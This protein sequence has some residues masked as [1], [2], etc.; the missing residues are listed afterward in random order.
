MKAKRLLAVFVTMSLL[1]TTCLPSL[2]LGVQGEAGN[3]A[4]PSAPTQEEGL[5]AMLDAEGIATTWGENF[6]QTQDRLHHENLTPVDLSE[7]EY[8]ELDVYIEDVDAL[9]AAFSA[10]GIDQF[11]FTVSANTEGNPADAYPSRRWRSDANILDQIRKSG[12][13]HVKIR[14]DAFVPGGETAIHE[15]VN[16]ANCLHWGVFIQGSNAG[17]PISVSDDTVKI[18]N[19][20]G[21]RIVNPAAPTEAEGLVGMLDAE[22]VKTTWGENFG[23]TQ[24]RLHHE[25][26][27]PVD[28]SEAEYIELD[29]YIEDVDAL[30]A[31]F[32]ASGIDQFTF[33]VSAN[34]E[35]NPAD[36]YPSRRWRSDANILD[37]I[38]KS[39]WNHVKIR[40][41]A[42]VPGGE[43][44][45]HEGVN[46]ANCL[47]W[48]VFI[49]GSNAG[50]PISVSE[51]AVKIANIC[52]TRI[53][54]PAAPTEAEGLDA[55]LDADGALAVWG[56]TF[57]QTQDRLYRVNLPTVDLSAADYIELDVYIEDYAALRAAW[58]ALGITS[59][60]FAISSAPAFAEGWAG[61][62]QQ[63][64][65]VN[66]IDRIQTSGWNHVKLSKAE[67]VAQNGGVDWTQAR[68]WV[69][70]VQG[71]D[72]GAANGVGS[73]Y[74]KIANVCGTA[75][76]IVNPPATEGIVLDELG[77]EAVWGP[78][79]ANAQ[80]NLLH[81]NLQPVDLS[82][83]DYIEFD[84][85]IE[86]REALL[87]AWNAL[88]IDRF[89]FGISSR[90]DPQDGWAGWKDRCQVNILDRIQ[91]SGWNHIKI[92]RDAFVQAGEGNG[93]DWTQARHWVTFVEGVQTDA[94]SGF[95]PQLVK[96]ANVCGTKIGTPPGIS[97]EDEL[98]AVLDGQGK[99]T[100]WGSTFGGTQMLLQ[101]QHLKPV[102][103]ENADF[104]ELD[105][106][107]EDVEALR[108]AWDRL[109]TTSFD[110][111]I[112]SNPD[113]GDWAGWQQRAQVNL[114]DRITTS[115]WNHIKLNKSEFQPVNGGVDWSQ[116]QHWV[117][118][119]QG[120]DTASDNGVGSHM[121]WI[122]N[123]CG[124]ALSDPDGQTGDN[125]AAVLPDSAKTGIWGANFSDVTTAMQVSGLDP[126]DFS[127][128]MYIEFDIYIQDWESLKSS[129]DAAGVTSVS[130]CMGS[131][132]SNAFAFRYEQAIT[133]QIT[134]SGWNH[135]KLKKTDFHTT[136]SGDIDWGGVASWMLSFQGN[137]NQPNPQG[138]RLVRVAN[139]CGTY[140]PDPDPIAGDSV[141]AVLPDSGRT[142]TWGVKF[143]DITEAT[144]VQNLTP[145]DFSRA[146]YIEFDI[147][148]EN[149]EQLKEAM[150]AAGVTSLS[151]CLGSNGEQAYEF[152]YQQAFT[153][154]IR[155]SGWNHIKLKR[156]LFASTGTGDIDWSRVASWM[157]SFQGDV[158]KANPQGGQLVRVT[159]ICG[160]YF[161]DPE[162]VAGEEVVAVL[163]DSDRTGVWG[164]QFNYTADMFNRIELEPT[165]FSEAIYIE[166]DLYIEDWEA[167]KAAMDAAGVTSFSFNLGS[168]AAN[169]YGF[170]YQQVIS[171]QITG[172]GWNHIK[173]KK[174]L[175][176]PTGTGDIDWSKVAT[177]QITYQGE[178]NQPNPQG[179]QLIR[180][181]NIVGTAFP[182]PAPMAGPEVVA[183]LP[184]SDRTG[185]WGAQFN[186]T[187]DMFN[188]IGLEPTDFS[189]ATYIEFD[190]Y[191]EDWEALKA[192]MDECGVTS[193]SFCLGSDP[194]NVYGFR[195]Q[196][197]ISDQVTQSGWN[198]IKLKKDGFV[199]TGTGDIDWTKVSTW[200][201]TFQGDV[202]KANPQADQIVR[203]TNICGTALLTPP[204]QAENVLQ[205]LST[206]DIS[207]TLGE[208]FHYTV[209][210]I[211]Q[212]R[213][214]PKD[215]S[216]ATTFEFDIF[217][218]DVAAIREACENS[219]IQA[220]LVFYVSSTPESQWDEYQSPNIM[221]RMDAYFLD[222]CQDG[223]NHVVIPKTAFFS[224]NTKEID[225]SGITAYGLFFL[226]SS[227]FASEANP[228]GNV[229]VRVANVTAC[230]VVADIPADADKPLA[231]DT[232][233]VYISSAEGL[234]DAYGSWNP[235][236]VEVNTSY[237]TEGLASISQE[238]LYTD[239]LRASLIKYL[240]D[241]VA[242][243]RDLETLKLDLFIDL[244][245]YA[246]KP[247]NQMSVVLSND[248]NGNSQYY[249][250]KVDLA[251]IRQG[252]NSLTLDIG[253]ASAVGSPDLGAVKAI[254]LRFDALDLD[255]AAYEYFH[256]GI[257]NLRY[258]SK[259]GNTTL[260][261]VRPDPE[262]DPEPAPEPA[263]DPEPLPEPT[264]EPEPE[265]GDD[266]GGAQP[267]PLPPADDEEIP[268]GQGGDPEPI[269]KHVTVTTTRTKQDL[270]TLGIV[271][272]I[273]AVVATGAIAGIV[274]WRRKKRKKS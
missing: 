184:D 273:E 128:A 58:D 65:Q 167:L 7:A 67:F 131:D 202:N 23:Q 27:T 249:S 2:F 84:L 243:M 212:R 219:E 216:Q 209:D 141:A 238:V 270:L 99:Q 40:K 247:G 108:S 182:D 179:N 146:I 230:G 213:I 52:G 159:N 48:G 255:A 90:E 66:I 83:A 20:C 217:I 191:I 96:I 103:L 87:A 59:F 148:I 205:I 244:P 133:D 92:R 31:A 180:V 160:T 95:V 145:T 73:Q 153:D 165:D 63:R 201:M 118:F 76:D 78:N 17:A 263:P 70:F 149:W 9:K 166:F 169:V 79:F 196:Q 64:A 127:Q 246:C 75:K 177:W 29:I 233:A 39:G 248:S 44:A 24:D 115:G 203:I 1:V 72:T 188:R 178:V 8:I 38:R 210:K 120:G 173:L 214:A 46:W 88:G 125:V 269:V 15:G 113:A 139:I 32:S 155:G 77:V 229:W 259:T 256:M 240:F 16:W 231:P 97:G 186:Y 211:Y 112:S 69:T 41:D 200:Q 68:H 116:A 222:Q 130:F 43:T 30:K 14:K 183:V 185:A 154:Q 109:G 80:M 265:P 19:I 54:N 198:H 251:K 49:Q 168:E 266:P 267:E 181:T 225:W 172:S 228:A 26:L 107:I 62:W 22:G 250:W 56:D 170:R 164:A 12:W 239:S 189:E 89:H 207:A 123:V 100:T 105:I 224:G 144:K 25:N 101:N 220:R 47:H 138:G 254:I 135:I 190:L 171:D 218:E 81:Q 11:T 124:T 55:M 157:L 194:S 85:Y 74:V 271:L 208:Y 274:L 126:S 34:T 121:V 150:D 226:N 33:T 245:Q 111:G 129:M 260:A 3:E 106:Y 6:G 261:I 258:L 136:G 158:D 114:L 143:G 117:T 28:L 104:I 60:D 264:P 51:D 122:T 91:K 134:K 37:Q 241:D 262:P 93:V 175:F 42:F 253:S 86:D 199:P 142:S 223:W 151:F 232:S 98:V 252:W 193:F 176:T 102:N 53:V 234:V 227:N 110:F 137:V 156:D 36:A 204:I 132:A 45:I 206:G 21:T 215:C 140:F 257:D 162:P 61:A 82:E 71:G 192:A 35:G 147:Y 10:S 50:A 119:V 235:V 221:Y 236:D 197:A 18:A 195:F 268:D 152:R 94:G 174:D 187:A 13:N 272:G 237:K 242:D 163:P 161:P 5:V 4:L 57:A